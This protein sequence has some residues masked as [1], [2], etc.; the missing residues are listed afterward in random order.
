MRSEETVSIIDVTPENIGDHGICGYKDPK[1]PGFG[2]K[3]A[4]VRAR[5]AEGMK[6]KVLHSA[7]HGTMGSIEYLP[8]EYSWRGI[9]APG[10]IV[11]HCLFIL[12]KDLKSKGYGSLLIRECESDAHRQKMYGVTVVASRSTWMAK[13]EVFLKNGYE[14]V[15][16]APPHYQL[17]VKKFTEDAPYPAFS[18]NWE[19]KLA[20][21]GDGL[22]IVYSDQCPY[23]A[24]AIN[25]IPQ[26]ARDEFGVEPRLIQLTDCKAAQNSPNPY[27][28][29]SVI[30]NGDLVA[31]HPIS[32]TRFANVMKKVT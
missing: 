26:V 25:E 8:G 21:Y 29:F 9:H 14:L 6:I 5:F 11:I 3:L 2:Q 7:R 18:G 28:V 24:K 27:G 22:T 4:W 10:Y 12:K 23:V 16:E 1:K 31:D 17:L 15:E 20:Q 19:K 32:K 13:K 30:W